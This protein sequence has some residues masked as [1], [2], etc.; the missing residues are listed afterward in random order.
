MNTHRPPLLTPKD[1]ARLLGVSVRT[2]RRN[3]KRMG[4]DAARCDLFPGRVTYIPA[5]AA[6]ALAK[7]GV[8]L[9]V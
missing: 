1:L 8:C 4:L 9:D 3:E 2:L 7:F 5:R 6:A